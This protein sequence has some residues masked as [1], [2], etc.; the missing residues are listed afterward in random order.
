MKNLPQ[1]IYLQVDLDGESTEGVDFNELGGITWCMDR[2]HDT[3]IEYVLV[4]QEKTED[5]LWHDLIDLYDSV[6][7]KS[8]GYSSLINAL[9]SKFNITRK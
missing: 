9:K 1:K 7:K 4:N 2:I 6:D 5:K 8:Y 3:D